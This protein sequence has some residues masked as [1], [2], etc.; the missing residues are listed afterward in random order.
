MRLAGSSV[1]ILSSILLVQAHAEEGTKTALVLSPVVVTAE[2]H[3]SSILEAPQSI[4][5]VTSEDIAGHGGQTTPDAIDEEPG[6]WVQKTALGGGSP[7]IRGLTGKQVLILVDGVR[8]NNST[9]RFG[10]NQYLN[11]IDPGVIEKIEVVRGPGSVLYGS[12]A[13][14]GVVNV[15]T[16]RRG[17]FGE[18]PEPGADWKLVQQYSSADRGWI[19]RL[20]LEGGS[21]SVGWTLGASLKSFGDLRAGRGESPVGLVDTNGVQSPSGYSESD[22]NAS[23]RWLL[24]PRQE[25]RL[26]YMF[27]RQEDVPRCDRAIA[28]DY[29]TNP[30]RYFYDPQQSSFGYLEY[31]SQ[32]LGA[33]DSFK[34]TVSWNDQLEG[35]E[36]RRSSW[37]YT[38]FEE[39]EV[40]TVGLAAQLGMKP[41]GRHRLTLGVETYADS[42]SSARWD[43][44]D[45]GGTT[46]RYPRFPDGSSYS[47]LGVYMRDELAL[48]ERIE[49]GLGVRYSRFEAS[50]DFGGYTF[51]VIGPLGEV[52][53]TYSDVT[54]SLDCILRLGEKASLYANIARGFRAPNM[55]D[56]AVNGDWSSGYD[57]PNPYLDPE[58]V[59]NYELGVKYEDPASRS[60]AGAS[61]FYANYSDLIQ[62]EYL[63]PGADGIPAT[64]DDIYHFD[65]VAKAVMYGGELWGKVRVHETTSDTWHVF[66]CLSYVYGQDLTA[67][68]PL[69]KIPPLN[70]RL[71]VRREQQGKWLEAFLE[72]ASKQD[73]LSPAD[74]NDVRI[75]DGGTPAWMTVNVRG[76]LELSRGVRFWW[77][78]YNLGDIR[79]RVHASGLD[80]PGLNVVTR[81]EWRF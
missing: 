42:I 64:T 20:E 4:S 66:G 53:E 9:F 57:V 73:R 70:G 27:C 50:M 34:A 40:R 38:R 35:R 6:V 55:D 8:F 17:A 43:V 52:S 54:W 81:L 69:S 19:G 1:F 78:A 47:S 2:R 68:V 65:N 37:T 36:R 22:F 74:E 3:E 63:D 18:L 32:G 49:L 15:F 44:Q 30:E 79:Y 62:R 80:A 60:A 28:S 41:L 11:T 31:E 76:G 13:L 59:I 75:P 51:P 45:G 39:D 77:G 48:S 56:L 67:D 24:A 71:G 29:V 58:K 12:D 46:V 61:L 10:P 16:H 5:V 14:G 26:F 21:G 33:L 7:F 25:L 23:L 72:G